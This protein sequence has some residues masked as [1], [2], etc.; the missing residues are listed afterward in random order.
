M[1]ISSKWY[2]LLVA[3]LLFVCAGCSTQAGSG[4]ASKMAVKV[5]EVPAAEM[6][7]AGDIRAVDFAVDDEES[8]HV[9][10][11]AV[12]S[13]NERPALNTDKI[14]YARGDKGG[15]TWSQ[16]V[17][18]GD[19]RLADEMVRILIGRDGLH[20]VFGR[21][22]RHFVSG[23]GG[24][25]WRELEP[26]I[27]REQKGAEVFDAVIAG[28]RIVVAYQLHPKPAYDVSKRTVKDDQQLY[29]VNWSAET[30]AAPALI[31]SF[32]GSLN[33]PPPP[34]L[35]VEGK[36]V[37]LMSAINA[38][39]RQGAAISVEGKLFYLR[40]DDAGV[41]WSSPVEASLG[42]AKGA[43]ASGSGEIQAVK[44]I[45]LL[46]GPE[47]LYALYHDTLLFMTHTSDG[48]TWSPSVEIGRHGRSESIANFTSESVS[49]AA[50][51]DR[52]SL[53]WIDTRF[54]KSDRK[55]W[56]PL[57]GVP[58]S[59]EPDWVNNDILIIPASDVFALAGSGARAVQSSPGRMTEQQSYA[60]TVRV[61][62]S[63]SQLFVLWSG[64]SKVG[65][66]LDTFGQ[67]PRLFYTTLPL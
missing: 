14:Y 48:R 22:L 25:S 62:A 36:R 35:A 24:T 23:D 67:R 1:F 33:G 40:S 27:P 43:T 57:G 19:N 64:R 53:V 12:L 9:V 66:R 3:P 4:E 13:N 31:A 52:G 8:L 46:P 30:I 55:S 10:W 26:F 5:Y 34:A 65:K 2:I 58:W 54:R 51:G 37:H 21:Q 11:R 44:K 45:E 42:A 47:R 63:K 17:I 6:E 18:V 56:N 16:P 32:P 39:R 20:L 49:A 61:R 50:V 38:E 41:T 15:A 60:H 59:D 29:V 7:V 28:D